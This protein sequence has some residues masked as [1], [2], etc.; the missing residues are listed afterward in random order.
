MKKDRLSQPVEFSPEIETI[1]KKTQEPL[2]KV[3]ITDDDPSM[4][5]I[6]EQVL[7][8]FTYKKQKLLLFHAY[9]GKETLK[10]LKE[11]PD[12]AIVVLDISLE[13]RNTGLELIHDIRKDLKNAITQIIICTGHPDQAP[14]LRI[15]EKYEINDYRIKTELTT[16]K[17]YSI[18]TSSL[19]AYEIKSNLQRELLEKQAIERNLLESEQRFRDI[20]MN[21]GDWIWETDVLGNF[22]YSSG[23]HG[24]FTGYSMTDLQGKHLSFTLSGGKNI[25]ALNVIQEK[26]KTHQPFNNIEIQRTMDNGKILCFLTSANPMKNHKGDFLGYRGVDKD[27]TVLKDAQKGKDALLSQLRQAQRLESIGTLAG[28]IAHDFNNILGAILGYTQIL[29]LDIQSNDKGMHYTRQIINGCNRA[30]NLILQI[31]DFSRHS[32]KSSVKSPVSPSTIIKEA[33]KLLR[34]SLPSSIKL[35]TDISSKAGYIMADPSQIHHITMNLCTNASQAMEENNGTIHISVKKIHIDSWGMEEYKDLVPG[36]YALIR[37]RDDG[38]GIEPDALEKIFEPYF[39][40]RTGGD[41]TGLGL[42]VVHGIVSQSGGFIKVKSTLG[43]GSE[44]S[45]F[46]PSFSRK[47]EK[48]SADAPIVK[49]TGKILFIDDEQMLVDLGRSMLTRLGYN[50]VALNSAVSG[51]E[52]IEKAPR[53]FDLV[54]TDLTMPDMQG[55]QL[56]AK[57]KT[58][59]PDM[60]IL[61]VTGLSSIADSDKANAHHIDSLLSKPLSMN[62]LAQTVH[63]L[64]FAKK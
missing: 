16:H 2:W 38:K 57:I 3:L 17:W 54:I 58:I 4:H 10:L 52:M 27:I 30:K 20:A 36:D 40:T 11:H 50:C 26:I 22:T 33:L 43:Q 39:S 45:L 37:I 23:N 32:T 25:T 51:L 24:D 28:G 41:G 8:H 63:N 46:F 18:M 5:T 15:I 34:A 31:L 1:S 7:S 61:L 44:F 60:P 59:R 19:R 56:A 9:S 49:G 6:T 64:L 48:Q 13:E 21:L 62:A 53:D 55:T 47:K 35:K 42:S 14:E 12:T 29:Q